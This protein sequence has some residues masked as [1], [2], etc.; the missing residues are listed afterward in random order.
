MFGGEYPAGNANR[1]RIDV[2][3]SFF[4]WTWKNV[5]KRNR[6][7]KIDSARWANR[8]SFTDKDVKLIQLN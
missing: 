6:R 4:Y 5:E 8:V 3:I 2:E 1:Y 7:R